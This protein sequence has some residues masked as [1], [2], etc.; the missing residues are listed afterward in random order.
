MS[1]FLNKIDQNANAHLMRHLRD[2]MQRCELIPP[3]PQL[4]VPVPLVRISSPP[5]ASDI[6]THILAKEYSFNANSPF[7]KSDVSVNNNYL[8]NYNNQN[9]QD[10]INNTRAVIK[11]DN[12]TNSSSEINFWPETS[13]QQSISPKNMSKSENDNVWRPW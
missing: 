5:L 7:L 8:S 6:S 10:T 3:P 2:C 1:Q 12:V 11:C 9:N 4:A 13:N